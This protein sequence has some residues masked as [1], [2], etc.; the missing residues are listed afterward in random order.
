MAFRIISKAWSFIIIVI[1]QGRQCFLLRN[2]AEVIY[3]IQN[4]SITCKKMKIMHNN[5]QSALRELF[6]SQLQDIYDA[7]KQLTDALP[8]MAQ[9]ATSDEL[10]YSYELHLDVTQMQIDRLKRIFELLDSDAGNITC[11]AMEGLIEEGEDLIDTT[12]E[13]SMVRD[14]G[15]IIASQKIEHYEIAAYGSL[16]AVAEILNLEEI[17]DLLQASLDEEKYT[18]ERLTELAVGFINEEA[19]DEG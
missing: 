10:R 3:S 13:G 19:E 2:G 6:L 5:E 1:K 18:D 17:A 8:I 15:L 7:E 9:A 14:C 11:T 12:E 4:L 16:R